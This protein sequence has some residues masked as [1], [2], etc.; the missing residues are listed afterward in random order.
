[1]PPKKKA[2]A[3]PVRPYLGSND[4]EDLTPAQSVAH[5]ILTRRADLLPSVD[6]I[7]EAWLDEPNAEKA[8]TLFRDSLDNPGDP[9]RDPR[10]AIA[11]ATD[12]A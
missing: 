2:P 4:P 8:L 7:M 6:R 12:P 1:M 10:A 5:D 9:Y 11:A 3:H